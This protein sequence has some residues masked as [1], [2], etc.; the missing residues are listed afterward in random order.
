MKHGT[1]DDDDRRRWLLMLTTSKHERVQ[2]GCT[3]LFT[4]LIIP[5][6]TENTSKNSSRNLKNHTNEDSYT[7]IQTHRRKRSQ[8][9]QSTTG[10]EESEE[11]RASAYIPRTPRG[12]VLEIVSRFQNRGY[13]RGGH[14]HQSGVEFYDDPKSG[15]TPRGGGSPVPKLLVISRTAKIR[16]DPQGGGA[17][18]RN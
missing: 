1:T 8:N 17:R 18:P 4:S 12:G 13:P 9:S 2:R 6:Q 16:W 11:G 5:N 15:E 14:R 7:A 10:N 3:K